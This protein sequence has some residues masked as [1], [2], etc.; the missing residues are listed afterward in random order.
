MLFTTVPDGA[1]HI[2]SIVRHIVIVDETSNR[3][4]LYQGITSIERFTMMMMTKTRVVECWRHPSNGS[5]NRVSIECFTIMMMA[6]TRVIE[7]CTRVIEYCK[8]VIE[9]CKR[10]IEY[11]K[12][13]IEYCKRVIEYCTSRALDLRRERLMADGGGAGATIILHRG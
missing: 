10:V 7:Y 5:Y 3:W 4:K 2:D 11:C 12:R 1:C 8:R 9:Y 13:V 6:M